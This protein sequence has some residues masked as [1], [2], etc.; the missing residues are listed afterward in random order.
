V[1]WGIHYCPTGFDVSYWEAVHRAGSWF[2]AR[3]VIGCPLLVPSDRLGRRN[4]GDDAAALMMLAS[5]AV[6]SICRP[7]CA[8]LRAR[9]VLGMGLGAANAVPTR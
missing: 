5:G 8:A 9:P 6:Y 4:A 2:A 3:L 1:I 7:A